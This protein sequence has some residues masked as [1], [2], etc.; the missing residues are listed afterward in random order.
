MRKR[1]LGITVLFIL[2]TL[3]GVLGLVLSIL[4]MQ[5]GTKLSNVPPGFFVSAGIEI[6]LLLSI[7]PLVTAYGL[8]KGK[9]WS[10]YLTFLTLGLSIFTAT[11]L[12]IIFFIITSVVVSIYFRKPHVKEYFGMQ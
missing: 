4:L 11:I 10:I 5:I 12:G 9:K 1:P 3:Y 2:F 7:P 8:L 6:A